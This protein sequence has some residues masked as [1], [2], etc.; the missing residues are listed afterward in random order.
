MKKETIKRGESIL[1]QQER[2][3]DILLKIEENTSTDRDKKY[4]YRV[5][6][7]VH[8][9]GDRTYETGIGLNTKGEFDGNLPL[10]DDGKKFIAYLTKQYHQAVVLLFKS[11]YDNLQKE[12]DNLKD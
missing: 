12:L 3:N 2:V 7:D 11:E 8:K 5:Q 10:S 1:A 6:I 4:L 9:Q